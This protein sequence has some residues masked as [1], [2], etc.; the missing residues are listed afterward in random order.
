MSSLFAGFVFSVI[1]FWMLKE[2]R[3]KADLRLV[4]LSIFLIAY[5]YFTANPYLDWGIGCA[6]CAGA[7]LIW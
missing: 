1:G 7:Y 4:I 6:L 2:A 5:T 3:K